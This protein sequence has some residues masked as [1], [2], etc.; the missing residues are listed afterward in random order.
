M[1]QRRSTLKG[2]VN[3]PRTRR[4]AATKTCGLVARVGTQQQA[5]CRDGSIANQLETMR[6]FV[7]SKRTVGNKRWVVAKEYVLSGVSGR[8]SLRS[9][10][11]AKLLEDMKAGRVNTVVCTALDRIS[12]SVRDFLGFVEFLNKHK[13]EFSC[14]KQN[15]D[16]TTPQG[17]LLT[18][19]IAALAEF[20][21]EQ[22]CE[23]MREAKRTR[24]TEN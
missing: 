9:K 14:L 8:D 10:E 5:T 2:C 3:T 24:G 19:V 4:D 21:K 13:V 17:K 1:E 12:R 18:A 7:K 20:E 23:R 22:T 15:Y 16:T 11:F 6:S